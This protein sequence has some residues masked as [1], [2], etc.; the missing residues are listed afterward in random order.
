MIKYEKLVAVLMLVFG[1]AVFGQTF[2]ETINNT[3]IWSV[4][5]A[6]VI[7]KNDGWKYVVFNGSYL[8]LLDMGS[9]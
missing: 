7:Q 4:Y 2:K 9:N 6:S 3:R 8:G 5:I 1:M